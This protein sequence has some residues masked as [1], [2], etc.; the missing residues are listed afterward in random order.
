MANDHEFAGKVAIVTGGSQGVGLG[1]ARSFLRAG[2]SVVTCARTAF[3]VPPAATDEAQLARCAHV[4]ADVRV[5]DDIDRVIDATIQRFGRIDVLV[6]NA[7]GQP[8]A[9]IA[10]ASPRFIRAIVELNLT[11]PIVFAQKAY[12]VM[13]QQDSGGAIINISSQASM[14]GGGGGSLTPYGAAKAGLNHMTRSLAIAWGRKV[15]VNCV[16]LGWVETEAMVDLL[17]TGDEA[18]SQEW[19]QRIPVG[20]MGTPEE[21]GGICVFLASE[22]A[23][24]INGTTIWADGGGT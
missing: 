4:V 20:R 14:P 12:A 15:R 9:E 19:L 3:D 21:I 8:P 23:S 17:L 2:A 1:I 11:A 16:S 18:R 24:Y 13:S 10:T 7:G 22:R 5:D 6:N